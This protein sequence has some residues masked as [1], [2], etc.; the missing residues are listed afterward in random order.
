M[1]KK[2]KKKL[3]KKHLKYAI[4]KA[5]VNRMLQCSEPAKKAYYLSKI[6]ELDPHIFDKVLWQYPYLFPASE[7]PN[8]E[9]LAHGFMSINMAT[10]NSSRD[11]LKY[12]Y[13]RNRIIQWQALISDVSIKNGHAYLLLNHIIP[14]PNHGYVVRFNPMQGFF[15]EYHLWLAV[16]KIF[17]L[18]ND[19]QEISIGDVITGESIINKYQTKNTVKYGLGATK[20]TGCGVIRP[21][22][23]RVLT[24]ESSAITHDAKLWSDYQRQYAIAKLTK[25]KDYD[26]IVKRFKSLKSFNQS[27]QPL[28]QLDC[29]QENYEHYFDML[30]DPTTKKIRLMAL[31]QMLTND[32]KS[33]STWLNL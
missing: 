5:Y 25:I 22:I 27:N 7:N 14:K 33:A 24:T 12:A 19:S 26:I 4:I 13:E 3:N 10:H 6:F 21:D 17:S 28:V 29:Y 18:P 20:I 9:V 11:E 8:E 16:D 1:S 23:V 31:Q 2:R 30:N 15:Y 32:F